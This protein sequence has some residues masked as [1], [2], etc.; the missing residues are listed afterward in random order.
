M[1]E[2]N[3][4]NIF[5]LLMSEAYER[6]FELIY[7]FFEHDNEIKNDFLGTMCRVQRVVIRH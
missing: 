5:F 2:Q 3:T 1:S 6:F 4:K 7:L